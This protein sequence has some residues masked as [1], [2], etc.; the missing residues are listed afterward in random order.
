MHCDARVP[1]VGLQRVWDSS[2]ARWAMTHTLLRTLFGL[3]SVY[4][5]RDVWPIYGLIRPPFSRLSA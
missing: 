4:I 1:C 5:L 3:S 2:T